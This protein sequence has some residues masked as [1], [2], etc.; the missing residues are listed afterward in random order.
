MC[1]LFLYHLSNFAV[2]LPQYFSV[3]DTKDFQ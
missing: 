1:N 2:V 3:G